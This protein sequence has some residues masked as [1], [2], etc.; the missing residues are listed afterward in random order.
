MTVVVPAAMI[1][2]RQRLG[3]DIR[4]E[5]WRGVYHVVPPASEEHQRIGGRIYVALF[6]VVEAAGFEFRYEVGV[7]DPA[8]P[9][10][11]DYCVPDLVVFDN[12]YRIPAGVN[13]R[14]ELVIEIRSPGDDSLL[15][16]PYYS[17]V[18]VQELLIVERDTKEVRRWVLH[19]HGGLVEQPAED[20]WH[21]LVALP[22]RVRAAEGHLEIEVDS[23]SI[24]TI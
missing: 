22:T 23:G 24:A 17:Q 11:R 15:K 2:E 9:R 1:A 12:R 10:E 6:P 3:L 13:G 4:D 7:F 20:G 21:A 8:G 5:V 14:A 18:G 16:V 19:A